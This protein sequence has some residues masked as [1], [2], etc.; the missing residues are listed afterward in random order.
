MNYDVIGDIHGQFGKLEKLLS[1]LGYTRKG[2]TWGSPGGERQAVFVGD[3]IDRGPEQ[4]ACVDAVRRMI[5][6]G[7]ARCVMGN[8]EFNAIAY[9]T[10]RTGCDGEYLRP[11]EGKNRKQHAQFLQ[12]V[13]EGSALHRELVDWFRT[14]PPALDLGPIRVVHAWWNDEYVSAV[15]DRLVGRPLDDEFLQAACTRGS[16]EWQAME[17]LTKGMEI[18][19]PAGS[20]FRDKDE[21]ER[22]EIRGRWWLDSART[23]R[24][25]AVVPADQRDRIPAHPLPVH[26]PLKPIQGTPVF[27]GHY[28][29]EG[30]PSLE[31]SKFGCVDYSEADGRPLVG[32]RWQG[33]SELDGA[34]FVAVA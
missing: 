7:H 28:S 17:G 5:D 8:H 11:N 34:H 31:V 33:E 22:H 10:P 4:V 29:M 1:Q 19:L 27:V 6:A 12:Q 23:Y 32:Y 15:L 25:Y 16:P 14:L 20:S 3:L 18:P 9:A 30:T 26:V 13:G 2:K 24:D 21:H